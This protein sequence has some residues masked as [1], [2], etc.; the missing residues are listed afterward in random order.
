MADLPSFSIPTLY[1]PSNLESDPDL[2]TEITSL[3]KDAFARSKKSDPMKWQ[4]GER[5]RFPS[6][7]L[8]LE[9]LGSEGVA[10]VIFDEDVAE[11]KVIAV[12][13]AV[14]WQGGWRK[15]GAGIEEGWEIKAVAVDGDARYLGR[16][17]A[18]QL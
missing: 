4:Q 12:A 3:I 13:A 6:H 8:Y 15:E 10:A 11:R 1:T 2:V 5:K 14:P 17:L 7:D 9:M 18:V 16:G